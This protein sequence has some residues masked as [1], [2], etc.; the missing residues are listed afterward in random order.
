MVLEAVVTL[1]DS[2]LDDFDIV[3]LLTDLTE[4]CAQLLDVDSAGLLLADPRRQLRLM[5]AT[6]DR[7]EELELLQLQADEGP[8]L[9]CF[10]TGEPVSTADLSAARDRWPRFAPAATARRF[11][12][13]PRPADARRRHG[14]RRTGAVRHQ[15]GELDAADL[16]VGRSLAH[17]A[18]VAIVQQ[19]PP[20]PAT[21]LP[22][23]RT[24]LASRVVVEQAKGFLRE[25]L[26][27]S[28]AEAFAILRG[29]A[30]PSRRA[31]Q[32]RGAAAVERPR[33]ATRDPG[34]TRCGAVPAQAGHRTI[35]RP[36][37][38]SRRPIDPARACAGRGPGAPLRPRPAARS[39][40]SL[41]CSV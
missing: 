16:L 10:L 1:V 15:S 33:G 27:V 19:H 12:V 9:E 13:R 41:M 20:T 11:R 31:P 4:R 6:S 32:R 5:A 28:V 37:A 8:C 21:V 24:A 25:R 7:T 22:H 39:A 40:A 3:E 36:S 17:V 29:Y 30:A 18:S 34:R 14:A 38:V 23:L 26:D 2:L 35:L